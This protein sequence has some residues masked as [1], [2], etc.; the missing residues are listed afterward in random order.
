MVRSFVSC[1]RNTFL[2]L[3]LGFTKII[4]GEKKNP[5]Y[6]KLSKEISRTPLMETPKEQLQEVKDVWLPHEKDN[7]WIDAQDWDCWV[8]W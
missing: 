2:E 3:L 4:L 6:W 8:I 5:T 1:S 7:L